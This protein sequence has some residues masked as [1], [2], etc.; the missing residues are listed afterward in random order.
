M[1]ITKKGG[2][3]VTGRIVEENDQ[4]IVVRLN[5]LTSDSVQ[6]QKN[7]VQDRQASKVSPMPEGLVNVLKQEEI[8]DLLAYIESG[9]KATATA[10]NAG[11]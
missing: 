1:T 10:F 7:Q 6:V 9:G 5:P 11:N 4:R 3:E 8:L 2:E